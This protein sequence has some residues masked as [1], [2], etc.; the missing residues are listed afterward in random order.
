M[1][2]SPERDVLAMLPIQASGAHDLDHACVA[3]YRE[4]GRQ[5][6]PGHEMKAPHQIATGA[7]E[8]ILLALLLHTFGD[9]VCRRFALGM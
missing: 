2:A 4:P 9:V 8:K 5:C 1:R 3:V 7:R 6:R